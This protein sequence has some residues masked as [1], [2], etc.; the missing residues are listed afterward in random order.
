[1][2]NTTSVED[3]SLPL[4]GVLMIIHKLS[5]IIKFMQKGSGW[6]SDHVFFSP[7]LPNTRARFSI[8]IVK[9]EGLYERLHVHRPIYNY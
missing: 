8:I 6:R 9:L 4:M 1:M 2:E 7:C 3:F 5:P